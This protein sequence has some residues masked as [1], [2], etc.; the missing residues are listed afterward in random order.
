MA[1]IQDQATQEPEGLDNY[2]A[3]ISNEPAG[4]DDYVQE[5]K[6]EKFGTVGQQLITGAESIAKGIAGPLA[7]LAETALGVPKE[8]ILAREDVNP[9][10]AGLGEAAGLGGGLLLGTGEGA[11][12]AKAGV[13]A[14]NLTKA[15]AAAKMARETALL[16]GATAKEATIAAEAAFQAA[17]LSARIGSSAVQQAAEMA[18]YESGNQ[19]SRM[20][21]EDP[22]T[23]AESAVSHIGLATALGGAGGVLLTGIVSPLWKATAG[24]KV[25]KILTD[26]TG[27]LNGA[28]ASI[29]PEQAE[30]AVGK[31]GIELA[32]EVRAAMSGNPIAKERFDVLY[33]TQNKKVLESVDK[34]NRDAS[35]S[36]MKS[37]GVDPSDIEVYSESEAGH[38]LLDT[39]KKE[40]KEKYEPIAERLRMRDEAA[41]PLAVSD[42]ARLKLYGNLL[43]TG[44]AKMGTDSPYY[45]LYE[46]WGNRVLAKDTI[47]QL[48]KLKTEINGELTKAFR[49]GDTNMGGVLKDI[50]TSI[51]EFQEQQ[52]S[53]QAAK[54]DIEALARNERMGLKGVDTSAS[55]SAG[56][57]VNE[58][59][60]VNRAY[61][62]FAKLMD[63]LTTHIGVGDF[64]GAGTLESKLMNKVSA[65][66]LLRKFSI[67]NNADFIKY[68]TQHFPETL[69][70]VQKSELKKFLK[71]AILSAKGENPVN[72]KKLH[73]IVSKGMAG[74]KEYVESLISP[75]AIEKVNSAKLILDSIAHPKSS[76]TAGWMTKT[77]SKMPQSAMAAVAML[78]GKNPV[79]GYLVGEMGH[80]LGRTIP[81]AVSL[82]YLRFIGSNQP[83]KSEGFKAMVD[84]ITNTYKG[85]NTLNKAISGVFKS[86]A[87]VL[88]S[89]SIPSDRD[90]DKLDKIVD[91]IQE[92]PNS[93]YKTAESDV[94]YYLPNHQTGLSEVTTRAVSYLQS[95][96][97][98]PFKASPLDRPI[99]PSKAEM[100]RYRRALE[101]AQS[102]AIVLNHIKNGTLLLNDI[103]DLGAM[104]PGLYK[105]MANK[106]SEE[107]INT[108]ADEE[109]IPYKTRMGLSL[110]LGQ[111]LDSSMLPTTILAS[112]ATYVPKGG[113]GP[114]QGPPKKGTSALGKTTKSYMTPLQASEAHKASK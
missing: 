26:L 21:L 93:I 40:F 82:G 78:V 114:M 38:S 4:L 37:L 103:K 50:K 63:E 64:R 65:E 97:P 59:A 79:L 13:E 9:I 30:T 11:L 29:L 72:I 14:A 41:A 96:K 24:P 27:H 77:F 42:E 35:E 28:G 33:E 54:K 101:I 53:K 8:D 67:R 80:H 39:F 3:Q 107:M 92:A 7:P 108:Q 86:G 61:S 58:R 106:L 32:P 57:L 81:D 84:F 16:T 69:K 48:D 45:K 111:P 17:P 66:E 1:G 52:I 73:E 109:P 47:G 20:I 91:N 36:V 5:L 90:L 113:P 10:T 85:Q 43:E 76:G 51:N 25:E 70:E 71:P 15:G 104:Y 44:M 102:P 12:L 99:E 74:Q 23:S 46:E 95:I 89:K 68:L 19:V 6:Q 22:E 87:Q 75:E 94:G 100:S 2:L 98:R 83:I 88:T 105:T 55:E 34:L 112:Q 31:L 60:E 110:F 62:E 56:R 18:V 49:S